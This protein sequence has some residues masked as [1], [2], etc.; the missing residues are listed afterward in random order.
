V[1]Y[2]SENLPYSL[3]TLSKHP[4]FLNVFGDSMPC[5]G[6]PVEAHK[7]CHP[8]NPINTQMN[9]ESQKAVGGGYGYFQIPPDLVVKSQRIDIIGVNLSLI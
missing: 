9:Q 7:V 2:Q 8:E 3:D 4:H 1:P 5:F 6:R